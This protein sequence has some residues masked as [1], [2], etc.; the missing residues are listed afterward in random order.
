MTTADEP[1]EMTGRDTQNFKILLHMSVTSVRNLP[2]KSKDTRY[3]TN[4]GTTII[5]VIKIPVPLN[6][7]NVQVDNFLTPGSNL[8]TQ[9]LLEY[10]PRATLYTAREHSNLPLHELFQIT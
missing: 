4:S 6:I 7:Y 10:G 8:G 9:A 1:S 2:F 5:I 3:N